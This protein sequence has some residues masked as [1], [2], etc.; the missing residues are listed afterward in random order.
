MVKKKSKTEWGSIAYLIGI[1]LVVLV[2]IIGGLMHPTDPT[3]NII[4]QYWPYLTVGLLGIFVGLANISDNEK[5]RFL[6]AS[7][8]L[9]FT[10]EL[11]GNIVQTV[12]NS[13][14]GVSYF[15]DLLVAF[16]AP[17]AAIVALIEVLS[18]AKGK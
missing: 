2:A 13:W 8:A 18:I 15:F 12:F 1:G 11:L 14:V 9:M 6:I 16:I 4:N 7:I 3:K 5:N 10:S 17:A